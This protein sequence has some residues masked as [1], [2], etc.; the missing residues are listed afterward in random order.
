VE[1]I[2]A[3][4]R[5]IKAHCPWTNGKVE[6][7]NRT[8]ATERAYKRKYTINQ[9]R[10]DAFAPWLHLYNTE[11]IHT[12]IGTTPIMRVSPTS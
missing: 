9:H 11:R 2:G 6:R 8:L 7:L 12:G 1:R 10:A 5:F 4:Q 3:Q